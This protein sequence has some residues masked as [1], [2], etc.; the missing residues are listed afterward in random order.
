MLELHLVYE[1]HSWHPL[2]AFPQVIRCVSSSAF[3]SAVFWH[4][5]LG[6]AWALGGSRSTKPGW[7]FLFL[8]RI[9]MRGIGISESLGGTMV[10]RWRQVSASVMLLHH[11]YNS[12]IQIRKNKNLALFHL[13][14]AA[15]TQ[16]SQHTMSTQRLLQIFHQQRGANKPPEDSPGWT[17]SAEATQTAGKAAKSTCCMHGG[18]WRPSRWGLGWF[19]SISEPWKPFW[20]ARTARYS[21]LAWT[22]PT[23]ATRGKSTLFWGYNL[24][25]K[26]EQFI[27]LVSQML[28]MISHV[29]ALPSVVAGSAPSRGAGEPSQSGAKLELN[30]Q[31][32]LQPALA[33]CSRHPSTDAQ[34]NPLPLVKLRS[35]I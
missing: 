32:Q 4:S 34:V 31:S 3:S 14:H 30:F 9:V 19:E 12:I 25:S 16:A 24:P 6:L 8:S 18:T 1:G 20:Y 21:R 27:F 2:A 13:P 28:E 17:S 29:I 15:Y 33:S 10:V 23:N 11:R 26:V 22:W 35:I 7:E 5:W